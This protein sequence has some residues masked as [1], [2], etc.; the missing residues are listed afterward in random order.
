MTVEIRAGAKRSE[1]KG[2]AGTRKLKEGP[3]GVDTAKKPRLRG[4]PGRVSVR[5]TGPTD[6]DTLW[7]VLK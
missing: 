1:Q 3:S 4:G 2:P 7:V 6:Q 5:Q